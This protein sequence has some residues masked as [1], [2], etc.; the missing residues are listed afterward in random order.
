[1]TLKT[2]CYIDFSITDLIRGAFYESL[3]FGG[4]TGFGVSTQLFHSAEGKTN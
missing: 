4:L 3:C 1:M 2:W